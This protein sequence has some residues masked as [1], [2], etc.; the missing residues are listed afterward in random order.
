[1]FLAERR[2][3]LLGSGLG[4]FD[5]KTIDRPRT[6]SVQVHPRVIEL[7]LTRGGRCGEG[8]VRVVDASI[9]FDLH[10]FTCVI[11]SRTDDG[12]IEEV[13]DDL[14]DLVI[15]STPAN[16]SI[17]AMFGGT[18]ARLPGYLDWTAFSM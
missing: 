6:P 15:M 11:H 5:D 3:L 1:M 8:E 4:W 17:R 18:Q 14:D 10:S 16:L 2:L 13:D 7:L 12:P 9:V